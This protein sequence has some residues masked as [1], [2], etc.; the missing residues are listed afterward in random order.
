[1]EDA[2]VSVLWSGGVHVLWVRRYNQ[3]ADI[4]THSRVFCS[5]TLQ[6]PY[7][8]ERHGAVHHTAVKC[9]TV[10]PSLASSRND[11]GH[12]LAFV[13]TDVLLGIFNGEDDHSDI[14]VEVLVLVE[15]VLGTIS[16]RFT[17]LK[18]GTITNIASGC[19]FRSKPTL[20]WSSPRALLA[21]SHRVCNQPQ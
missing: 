16:C 15:P 6:H 2:G 21:L 9:P 4:T 1:M 18:S 17:W 13:M 14:D 10:L 3:C 19:L 8:R 7:Y 5:A 12:Q 20:S 11:D